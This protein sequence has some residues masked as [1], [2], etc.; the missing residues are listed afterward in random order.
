[1]QGSSG[2]SQRRSW[3]ILALQELG[4]KGPQPGCASGQLRGPALNLQK[5]L[6][7]A[8]ACDVPSA[9]AG[10]GPV[11][12]EAGR[13]A[14]REGGLSRAGP[15]APQ[16]AAFALWLISGRR[17]GWEAWT[18]RGSTFSLTSAQLRT[19]PGQNVCL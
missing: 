17:R 11:L 14:P 3:I 4:G 15:D 16:A 10:Q 1:M 8:S 2:E 12:E 6:E 13:S 18:G 7:W 5:A 19:G 9:A